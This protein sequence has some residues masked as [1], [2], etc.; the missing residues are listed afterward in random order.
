M[1]TR[2]L[3]A[4]VGVAAMAMVTAA[5]AETITVTIKGFKFTPAE[6][7]AHVGDT[8]EWT[9]QDGTNHTATGANKEWDVLIAP[10][11]TGSVV[12]QTEGVF[13]YSCRFH[14]GMKGKITVVAN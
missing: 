4:A 12:A 1:F 9:N 7:T 10:G 13:A 2:M 8:I 11:A 6:V 3:V 14:P 5:S